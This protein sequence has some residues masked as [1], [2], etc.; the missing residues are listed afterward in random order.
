MAE[1]ENGSKKNYLKVTKQVLLGILIGLIANGYTLYLKARAWSQE[2]NFKGKHVSISF[3]GGTLKATITDHRDYTEALEK[4]IKALQKTHKSREVIKYALKQA[5]DGCNFV[6]FEAK[7]NENRFIQFWTR[8]GKLDHDFPMSKSNGLRPYRLAITGLL[9]NLDFVKKSLLDERFQT[10]TR[11]GRYFWLEK[12][13]KNLWRLKAKFDK[14]LDL[15]TKYTYFA[16]KN[17]LKV[18]PKKIVIKIG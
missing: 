8:K 14:N 12:E 2:Q 4:Q 1:K 15:C 10:F 13:D 9:T 6:T 7:D 11:Y 16:L 5:I 18:N 17:V 3:G